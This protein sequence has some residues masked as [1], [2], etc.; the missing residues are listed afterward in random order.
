MF[1]VALV[2]LPEDLAD[3]PEV[4]LATI[5]LAIRHEL[6]EEGLLLEVSTICDNCLRSIIAGYLH[7][8]CRIYAGALFIHISMKHHQSFFGVT[9]LLFPGLHNVSI[10]AQWYSDV[11]LRASVATPDVGGAVRVVGGVRY[12]G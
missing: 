11:R 8:W 5:R 4:D 7:D 9:F 10:T 6:Q 2:P 3:I 12:C 1:F